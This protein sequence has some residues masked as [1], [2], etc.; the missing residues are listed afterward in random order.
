MS[1]VSSTAS[2]Q[3]RL[4]IFFAAVFAVSWLGALP[5]VLASWRGGTGVPNALKPLQLL[6]LFGPGL[7][8]VAAAWWEGGRAA[9]WRLLTGLARWRVN[10]WW[11]AGVLLGPAV[12][13]AIGLFGSSWLGLADVRWAGTGTTLLVFG[14]GF[15]AYAVLNTEELAWRG[16][17][18]PRLQRRFGALRASLL[19]GAVWAAFHIP[20]FLLKGGH[21]AGHPP[22]L[23][24][25]MILGLSFV[26]TWVFNGTGGSV[27]LVHLLHQS[28]NAWAEAIPVFPAATHSGAPMAF[29]TLL[30]IGLAIVLARRAPWDG[31]ADTPGVR[32]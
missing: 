8:A 29:T 20:L 13:Y 7:V 31:G 27:L 32:N 15:V 12:V 3:L 4:P 18:L 17:A 9:A 30:V 16:Y 10:A 6:M 22:L 14:A 23:F 28:V 24:F 2:S 25:A 5:M 21:P 26:F 1:A 19:L 11:Y